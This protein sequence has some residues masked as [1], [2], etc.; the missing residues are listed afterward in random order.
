MDN[1]SVLFLLFKTLFQNLFNLLLA[2][3]NISTCF[4]FAEFNSLL[5][6]DDTSR[7]DCFA[8]E[9]DNNSSEKLHLIWIF[10]VLG[11]AEFVFLEFDI[12]EF[13]HIFEIL[14]FLI[15]R[16]SEYF[17]LKCLVTDCCKN[18]AFALLNDTTPVNQF[19]I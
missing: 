3:I 2:L 12:N 7:C 15:T 6:N 16:R 19:S 10:L 9:T 13:V 1:C 4:L 5:C 14:E 11:S 17:N 18:F 8:L